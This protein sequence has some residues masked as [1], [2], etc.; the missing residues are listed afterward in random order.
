M[1]MRLSPSV[2]AEGRNEAGHVRMMWM[3][4][5]G[6]PFSLL[7]WLRSACQAFGVLVIVVVNW[8]TAPGISPGASAGVDE[9]RCAL[10]H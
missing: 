2:D 4:W 5:W 7:R 1:T 8:S 6:F 10:S 3:G 9:R